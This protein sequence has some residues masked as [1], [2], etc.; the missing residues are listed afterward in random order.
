MR[1]KSKKGF[2]LVELIVVM[3]IISVL[4]VS[5]STML[6][7]ASA[8]YLSVRA[9][10]QAINLA[11][12]LLNGIND[13]IKQANKIYL[14]YHTT[15]FGSTDSLRFDTAVDSSSFEFDV[16]PNKGSEFF[17]DLTNYIFQCYAETNGENK[18]VV[19]VS[20]SDGSSGNQIIKSMYYQNL[21]VRNMT[22]EVQEN[23]LISIDPNL[24]KIQPI[25]NVLQVSFQIYS[26]NRVNDDGTP[27]LLYQVKDYNIIC[28]NILANL[29]ESNFNISDK[30]L[31]ADDL[32]IFKETIE[33][34]DVSQID[35]TNPNNIDVSNNTMSLRNPHYNVICFSRKAFE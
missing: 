13:E 24:P 21:Q 12:D 28:E 9:R 32:N 34:Y 35:F 31:G 17:E 7:S 2:T 6:V 8:T 10:S 29:F 3:F 22:F 19:A 15:D 4:S 5:L 26:T 1:Y 11:T 14:G 23:K 33:G 25:N 20:R 30:E 27:Q 18:S 16:P